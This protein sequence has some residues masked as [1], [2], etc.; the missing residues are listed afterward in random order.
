MT[1][2]QGGIK[3]QAQHRLNT[4]Q[5]FSLVK[6]APGKGDHT[7]LVADNCTT[8]TGS[9]PLATEHQRIVCLAAPLGQRPPAPLSARDAA[10]PAGQR[11]PDPKGQTL[12]SSWTW[13][14]AS[15]QL[16]H[17]GAGAA[18]CSSAPPAV[19]HRRM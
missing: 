6:A 15:Q 12:A 19:R 8:S 16:R 4:C 17:A 18:M 1:V 13:L 2:G 5:R 10:K 11:L 9:D 14:T 3:P 7:K